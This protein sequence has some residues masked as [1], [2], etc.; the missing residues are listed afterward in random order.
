[1]WKCFWMFWRWLH[2]SNTSQSSESS[3]QWNC[4]VVFPSKLIYQFYRRYQQRLHFKNSNFGIIFRQICLKFR[5]ILQRIVW[6]EFKFNYSL[7]QKVQNVN[8]NVNVNVLLVHKFVGVYCG[9]SIVTL[10]MLLTECQNVKDCERSQWKNPISYRSKYGWFSWAVLISFVHPSSTICP[11]IIFLINSRPYFQ[12]SW[13]M[14][15]WIHHRYWIH[16]YS[17]F[18]VRH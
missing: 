14:T 16:C 12:I 15:Y 8:V 3:S 6:G 13:L 1:M 5:N 7:W 9:G 4:Q 17:T 18:A 11:R 2:R 10:R